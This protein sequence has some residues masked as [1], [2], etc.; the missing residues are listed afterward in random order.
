MRS[1]RTGPTII[2]YDNGEHGRNLKKS[3]N[4]AKS[5]CCLR[6]R[7]LSGEGHPVA[8]DFQQILMQ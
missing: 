8:G 7:V 6:R 5:I 1:S 3:S 4:T 2:Q